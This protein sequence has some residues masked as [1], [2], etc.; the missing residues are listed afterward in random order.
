MGEEYFFL[1]GPVLYDALMI[2]IVFTYSKRITNI[3]Y[4]K[5]KVSLKI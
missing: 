3:L 1:K 4:I 5:K 2:L